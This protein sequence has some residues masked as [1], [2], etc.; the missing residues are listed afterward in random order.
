MWQYNWPPPEVKTKILE[1]GIPCHNETGVTTGK[2]IIFSIILNLRIL[3]LF[4]IFLLEMIRIFTDS[5]DFD[6]LPNDRKLK[7]YMRCL[8]IVANMMD[9]LTGAFSLANILKYVMDLP[10][11]VIKIVLK[12]ESGC[13]RKSSKISDAC[14]KSFV[15]NTCMKRNDAKVCVLHF[16]ITK[17][18]SFSSHSVYYFTASCPLLTSLKMTHNFVQKK[19]SNKNY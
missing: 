14:E 2:T 3:S 9:E 8:F 19:N 18:L 6:H 1:S 12:M 16:F 15:F 5:D 13:L 4:P 10:E 7:C 11:N 17:I